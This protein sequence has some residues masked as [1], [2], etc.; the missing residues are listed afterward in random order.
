M[1]SLSQTYPEVGLLSHSQASQAD[2][3]K[4]KIIRVLYIFLRFNVS[5]L[6]AFAVINKFIINMQIEKMHKKQYNLEK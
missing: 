2:S 6:C 4:K 1:L 5:Y 3:L